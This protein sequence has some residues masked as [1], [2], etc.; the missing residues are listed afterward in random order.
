[1]NCPVCNTLNPDTQRFCFQCGARLTAPSQQQPP[2]AAQPQA[3]PPVFPQSQGSP[4]GETAP[5]SAPLPF[6]ATPP[7]IPASHKETTGL[8]NGARWTGIGS[9]GLMFL[10]IVVMLIGTLTRYAPLSGLALL[11]GL[12]GLVAGPTA[13]VLGVLALIDN[14]VKT[15]SAGRR[16]A[17]LGITTGLSTLLLCCA[18]TLLLPSSSSS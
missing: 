17:I 8:A 6:A 12:P 18:L 2:Q 3:L 4:S 5:E 7:A 10:A 15:T 16:H 1:M 9:I 11:M 13:F 14:N